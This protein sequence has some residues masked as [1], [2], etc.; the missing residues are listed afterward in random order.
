M[1]TRHI[2][3]GPIT[4]LSRCRGV[5]SLSLESN[6]MGYGILPNQGPV[7]LTPKALPIFT[8][9]IGEIIHFSPPIRVL[10]LLSRGDMNM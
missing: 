4:D 10:P 7:I 1:E 2:G 9:T 6:F 3:T 8:Y 5:F